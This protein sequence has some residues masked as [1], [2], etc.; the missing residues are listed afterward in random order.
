[1]NEF[2]NLYLLS[3]IIFLPLLGVLGIL[4][5]P[6]SHWRLGK[7]FGLGSS[8]LGLLL[9]FYC[10][11]S[12]RGVLGFEFSKKAYD[13]IQEL[14][15]RYWI[16]LDGL[17][18]YLIGLTLLLTPMALNLCGQEKS[19]RAKWVIVLIIESALLGLFS[20]LDVFLC[21]FFL[22]CLIFAV[23]FLLR[24]ESESSANSYLAFNISGSALLLLC[25]IVLSK[26]AGGYFDLASLVENPLPKQQQLIFGGLFIGSL[27]LMS[28]LFPFQVWIRSFLREASPASF[29]IVT[30]L[31]LKVSAYIVFRFG[32]PL[33][34]HAFSH[35]APHI[36]L[37]S[38]I[39]LLGG[40]LL[41]LAQRSLMDRLSFMTL[42]HMGFIWMGISLLKVNAG[43]GTLFFMISHGFVIALL[44]LVL[45]VQKISQENDL[46][47][48][49][50]ENSVLSR[51]F[52]ILCGLALLGLPGTSFF[53]SL[54]L[55][56]WPA[57]LKSPILMILS[58]VGW[59]LVAGV[60]IFS[61]QAV[62]LNALWQRSFRNGSLIFILI[63][64]I[65]GSGLYPA[66]FLRKTQS[67]MKLWLSKVNPEIQLEVEE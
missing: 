28:G 7:G 61:L 5:F 48:G 32:Y 37:L 6:Q 35:Y 65:V 19:S 40:G 2:M 67:A 41:I 44:G 56:F 39:S 9:W 47:E 46:I 11:P 3:I 34:P 53:V 51:F 33:F 45:K 24:H 26:Q 8:I 27:V 50:Q 60:T 64:I 54:F 16:G 12:F 52:L 23:F 59:M 17:S 36:F 62:R 29:I 15:I 63:L 57:Y 13:W 14:G 58:L 43:Q 4:I 31:F 25:L 49:S 42:G 21:Y 38:T 55:N 30:G 18:F 22:E 10:L 1:M 20:A 66:P